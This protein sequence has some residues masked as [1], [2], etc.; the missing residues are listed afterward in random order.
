MSTKDLKDMFIPG[1][2]GV[3]PYLAGRIQE[4][5][6]FRNCVE[7]MGR[8]K[9]IGQNM[10][11]YGPRG[12]GKTALLKHLQKETH[13]KEE[14]KVEIMWATPGKMRTSIQFINL[15]AGKKKPWKRINKV[16]VNAAGPGASAGLTRIFHKQ[17][18][19]APVIGYNS[20]T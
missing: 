11:L 8:R 6:H 7:T 19:K 18:G 9:P 14:G 10:I 4:Q 20:V 2:G 17:D 12:N 5:K 3:P 1:D 13:Q 15:L 16:K